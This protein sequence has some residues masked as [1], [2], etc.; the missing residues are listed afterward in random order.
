MLTVVLWAVWDNY[1]LLFKNKLQ[2]CLFLLNSLTLNLKN[3]DD[4]L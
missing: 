1:D 2:A 4:S 3:Q